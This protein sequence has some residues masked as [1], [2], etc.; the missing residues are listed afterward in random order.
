MVITSRAT[1]VIDELGNAVQQSPGR[2]PTGRQHCPAA[3]AL[4]QRAGVCERLLVDHV[5]LAVCNRIGEH[6]AQ[7]PLDGV[8]VH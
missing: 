1:V 3:P 2:A 8:R 7:Q 4:V 6:P 5:R